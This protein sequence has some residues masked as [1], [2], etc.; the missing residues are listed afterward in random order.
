V[1]TFYITWALFIH[2][3]SIIHGFFI[4]AYYTVYTK[5]VRKNT[6][7]LLFSAALFCGEFMLSKIFLSTGYLASKMI[8]I[9]EVIQ[10]LSHPNTAAGY[11]YF[12]EEF[13]FNY[14]PLEL[15]YMGCLVFLLIKKE[16]MQFLTIL[17]FTS[18]TWLIIMAYNL[19][20]DA[21]IVYMNYYGLF[22]FYITFPFCAYAINY[23]SEKKFATVYALLVICSLAGIVR[24]GALISDQIDYYK[25]VTAQMKT[26]KGIVSSANINWDSIWV[27]WDL[28]FQSLLLSSSQNPQQSKTFFTCDVDSTR[29]IFT[30]EAN[31]FYNTFFS[32]TWFKP[33]FANKKYYMLRSSSYTCLNSP[34]DSL[35]KDSLLSNKNV[36]IL[37]ENK[38]FYLFKNSFR[39]VPVTVVNNTG[40]LLPST[41]KGDKQVNLTYRI[42]NKNKEMIFNRGRSS[43]LEMDIQS[44]D[45]LSTGLNLDC[46]QLH[47]GQAYY[48]DVDLVIEHK[49]RLGI[50]KRIKIV[51]L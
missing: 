20:K 50:N 44:G 19:N 5:T 1:A 3:I 25:R 15:L 46:T 48:V 17:A 27:S 37:A 18:G 29:K 9:K 10:F 26:S 43:A 51:L 11:V 34:Q 24:S 23:I 14:L 28:S 32:P 36:E 40:A 8:G 45:C 22:G 12:K 31:C 30:S 7:I 47:R 35:F 21:P 6:P 16:Y 41:P 2:V 33:P 49:R 39:T 13:L 42:L 38:T 4:L